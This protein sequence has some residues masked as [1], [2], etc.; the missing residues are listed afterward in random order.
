MYALG[1]SARL[2]SSLRW[3]LLLL[4][5]ALGWSPPPSSNFNRLTISDNLTLHIHIPVW[6][7][8]LVFL[9]LIFVKNWVLIDPIVCCFRSSDL[10][11]DR[12][13]LHCVIKKKKIRIQSFKKS[14]LGNF[15]RLLNV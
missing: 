11:V 5:N 12:D 15:L 10:W 9:G 14:F 13:R 6:F 7:S 3:I 8:F 1:F 4:L 2:S